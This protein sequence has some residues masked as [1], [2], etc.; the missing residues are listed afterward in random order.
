MVQLIG[1]VVL[2]VTMKELGKESGPDVPIRFK[3]TKSGTTDW[4]GM[5]LGARALD[6]PERGGLG[7][8][9]M[10]HG[11]AFSALGIHTDQ[12]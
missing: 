1:G 11:H 8:T 12:V 6:A 3:I 10:N 2:K 7:F 5:I 9:P 4:V